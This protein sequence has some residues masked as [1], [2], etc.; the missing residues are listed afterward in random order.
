[1]LPPTA[2]RGDDTKDFARTVRHETGAAYGINGS[3]S[4]HHPG[5]DHLLTAPI[6]DLTREARGPCAPHRGSSLDLPSVWPRVIRL[7]AAAV[8]IQLVEH[9]AV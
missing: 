7:T 3:R 4:K 5:S 1:M 2:G 6:K 9:G 8:W